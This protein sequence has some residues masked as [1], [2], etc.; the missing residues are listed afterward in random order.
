MPRATDAL[1]MRSG[2]RCSRDATETQPP[3]TIREVIKHGQRRWCVDAGLIEG[4][5]R[6]FFHKAK[7]AAEAQLAALAREQAAVGKVWTGLPPRERAEAVRIIGE[8]RAAGVTLAGVW[9]AYQ[10]GQAGRAVVSKA[11][12]EVIAEL[13]EAKRRAKRREVYLTNLAVHLDDFARGREG[14]AIASVGLA[15]VEAYLAGARS[16][17]SRL[18][19]L[20]RLSTL[21]SFAVRRGY[22]TANPCRLVEKVA[23]EW[24][25]PVI[26]TV[27]QCRALLDRTRALDA[28]FVPHLALCLFAGVRPAE[29]RRLT[30]SDVDLTAGLLTIDAEDA[31]TRQRR[32][33]ELPDAAVAW[34]RLGGH[35]P[36]LNARAR[37]ATVAAAA[38]VVPWPRDALR[39]SAASYW[40][41]LKGEVVTARNLGHSETVLHHHY[42]A[43]TT[44]ADARDFFA[45][46]P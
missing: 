14:V 9:Q 4:R 5:R 22:L 20:N 25:R 2:A 13:I 18:T 45:L 21:M 41:A 34:L 38:G 1:P 35:L 3:M 19:R 28:G 36:A 26:L 37:L 40:H 8:M 11:L 27:G 31:K 10:A 23:V 29:A 33:V 17:G 16:V 42:R 32:I 44:S 15:D 6:Q 46:L 24:Q 12:G 30:W 39:H 43:L 7:R